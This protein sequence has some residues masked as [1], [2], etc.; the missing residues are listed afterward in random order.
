MYKEGADAWT[1]KSVD[2]KLLGFHDVITDGKTGL[3]VLFP[4]CGK[5]QLMLT[6]EERRHHSVVGIEWSEVAVKQF[7][8]DN[9][10]IYDTKFCDVGGIQVPVYKARDKAITI[11]C[12][13]IFTFTDDNLGGFDC[14]FDHG[15]IGSFDASQG[16]RR[17][18]AD[19]M[20]KFTRSGG[21]MFVS[22]F[23][24]DHSEHPTMPFAVTEEEVMSLYK[25]HFKSPQLL[26]KYDATETRAV[27]KMSPST[28][29]PVWTFSRFSWKLMLLAK[30][31]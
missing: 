31:L 5:T 13:D 3:D 29:L 17:E 14:V 20:S 22:F 1:N 24:Y 19:I 21:R 25:E 30:Q 8:K 4:M 28:K 27:F 18:Y 2:Q 15:S 26:Q 6:F 23:D 11:Y 9:S 7:F 12:S 16:K 10:L